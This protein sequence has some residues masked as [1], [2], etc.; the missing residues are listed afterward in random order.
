MCELTYRFALFRANWRERV[1]LGPSDA[2]DK[3]SHGLNN[4]FKTHR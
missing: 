1:R 2:R 3:L 4:R